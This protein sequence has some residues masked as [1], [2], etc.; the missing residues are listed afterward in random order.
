MLRYL[1]GLGENG[2]HH[3]QRLVAVWETAAIG[4]VAELQPPTAGGSFSVARL[5]TLL[6]QPVLA[7][8]NPPD[9]PA[10]HCSIHNHRDDPLLPDQQ[11]AQIAVV[12]AD[13]VGLAPAG[14]RASVRWVAVRH[15]DDHVHLVA[16]LVRQDGPTV[17]PRNDYRRCQPV[18]RELEG[19]LGLR[20]G[21]PSS[22]ET[23]AGHG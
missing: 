18:A 7:G 22:I 3:D 1:F 10:W 17:W 13:G 2:E 21:K 5:A 20:T 9:K 12:F 23:G 11:W 6:E 16:T 4:G 15:A 8:N 19:L 14:D